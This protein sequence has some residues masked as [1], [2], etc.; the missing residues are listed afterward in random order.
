[1]YVSAKNKS[2]IIIFHL[3]YLYLVKT[4]VRIETSNPIR[5]RPI[6]NESYSTRT[7]LMFLRYFLV[8]KIN[9]WYWYFFCISKSFFLYQK[10]FFLLNLFFGKSNIWC[11]KFQCRFNQFNLLHVGNSLI[12]ISKK[13]NF[14]VLLISHFFISWLYIYNVIHCVYMYITCQPNVYVIRICGVCVC[15]Q[16]HNWIAR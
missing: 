9:F 1:M 8:S 13:N 10:I 5:I 3:G 11:L 4:K 2:Y 15:F 14:F 6:T 7:I 12:F 16:Q